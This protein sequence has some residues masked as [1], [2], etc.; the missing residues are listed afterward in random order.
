M[1]MYMCVWGRRSWQKWKER[2][3]KEKRNQKIIDTDRSTDKYTQI[4][5]W[6]NTEQYSKSNPIQFNWVELNWIELNQFEIK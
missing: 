4:I 3:E 6:Y 2:E 5:Y 1:C